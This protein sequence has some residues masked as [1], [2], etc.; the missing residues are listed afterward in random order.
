MKKPAGL[1]LMILFGGCNPLLDGGS[2]EEKP[3]TEAT[4]IGTWR[5][6]TPIASG[7][8]VRMTLRID[9]DHTMLWARRYSANP[10]VSDTEFARETWTWKVEEGILKAAKS[11]CRYAYPP[12]YVLVDDTCRAPLSEEV[13]VKVKGN[14]WAIEDADGSWV[15]RKDP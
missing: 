4:V 1:A 6:A 10:S 14:S 5:S 3:A 2:A 7:H 9:S 11:E 13:P 8:F 12:G 15:F